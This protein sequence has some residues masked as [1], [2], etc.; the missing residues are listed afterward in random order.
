MDDALDKLRGFSD[1][2]EARRQ[3]AADRA[4][5]RDEGD[6]VHVGIVNI[7]LAE[8]GEFSVPGAL[9]LRPIDE[10]PGEIELARA[11]KNKS[12]LSA[13]ARHA[14]GFSYELTVSTDYA[15]SAD[16]AM[17]IAWSF[18]SA[19]RIRTS[20]DFLAP[21]VSN[22]SWA[23]IA[24]APADSCQIRMIEDV[25]LAR[26]FAKG[27]T[28][29]VDDLAWSHDRLAAF[30]ELIG[31]EKFRLAVDCLCTHQQEG[32]LRMTTASLW[33]GIEALIGV[34]SEL[35]FRISALVATYLEDRGEK[36][37]A[38]YRRMK[39]LYQFRSKAVHGEAATD[40]AL[41][42]H[43]TEV[44]V[45]LSRLLQKILEEGRVPIGKDWDEMLFG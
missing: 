25:P 2:F 32:S 6:G 23:T 21:A 43:V 31:Q 38:L 19:V 16:N 26:V 24:S 29:S 34:T 42:S 45:I 9:T 12:L 39:S 36:R 33:A 11:L 8:P 1:Q 30:A 15:G 7:R 20:G 18:I 44:R 40:D 37:M 17:F 13:V 14:H 28:V 10:P 27:A 41:H 22:C 4:A 35:S 3:R 5:S